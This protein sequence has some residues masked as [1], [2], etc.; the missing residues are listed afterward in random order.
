MVGA[1]LCTMDVE[2]HSWNHPERCHLHTPRGDNQ[3]VS[4]YCHMSPGGE[5]KIPFLLCEGGAPELLRC[6]VRDGRVGGGGRF[7]ACDG[8]AW[9]QLPSS[10]EPGMA[11]L[12]RKTDCHSQGI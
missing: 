7:L 8:P 2:Q 9:G 3:N 1:V 4:R 10:Q 12:I 6:V 11:F 5:D